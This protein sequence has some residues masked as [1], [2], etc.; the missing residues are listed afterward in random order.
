MVHRAPGVHRSAQA[1]INRIR[2]LLAECGIVLPQE[3]NTVR[4]QAAAHLEDLPG[5]ANTVIGDLLSDVTRLDERIA[6]DDTHIRALAHG[7]VNSAQRLMR[8]G[9]VGDTTA[10]TIVAMIGNGHD[11]RCGRQIAAWLGL[12]PGQYGSGG[13]ARLGCFTKAGDAY[14]R[15]LL[16]LGARAVLAAAKKNTDS[17]STLALELEKRRGDWK[18]MVAIAA[19][20][21][22]LARAV[23]AKGDAFK[24]PA[25]SRGHHAQDHRPRLLQHAHRARSRATRR[26]PSTSASRDDHR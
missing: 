25:R 23:L 3:A 21:A 5:Y 22:R 24:L 2:G 26:N 13:K 8:L 12:V 11:F 1:A 18:E 7:E 9:G 4:R 14:L 15:S 16:V 17:I 20:N 19:K 10:T 6:D